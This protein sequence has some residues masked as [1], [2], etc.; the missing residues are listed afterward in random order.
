MESSKLTAELK[1]LE[2]RRAELAAESSSAS[3]SHASAEAGLLAGSASIAVVTTAHSKSAALQAACSS[4]DA[5]IEQVRGD[6]LAAE[7]AE[8]AAEAHERVRT[9]TAEATQARTKH[10][11]VARQAWLALAAAA[12]EMIDQRARY[13][14]LSRQVGALD[15]KG[16]GF[17]EWQQACETPF[18]PLVIQA[19]LIAAQRRE[20]VARHAV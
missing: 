15:G 2:S 3:A 9:L 8:A 14:E 17:P 1:A 7:Q 10:D 13:L 6:I 11:A 4:L 20:N 16:L 12:N 18:G 19:A 5:Q